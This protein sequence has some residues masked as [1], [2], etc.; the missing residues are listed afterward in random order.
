MMV[1]DL[2]RNGLR[3]LEFDDPLEDIGQSNYAADDDDLE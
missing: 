1:I 3:S 2:A